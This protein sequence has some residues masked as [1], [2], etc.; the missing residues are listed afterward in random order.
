M[1]YLGTAGWALSQP[2]AE[3]FPREGSQLQR[4][5][6]GLNA[7]E[8]N[9]SFY[10]PHRPAT[11]ARWAEAV[12]PDFRFCVKLPKAITHERRLVAC[13]AALDAFLD[14]CGELGQRLGCLLVQLPPSLV[15]DPAL[16]EAFLRALR[17][18]HEG[19][20]VIEPRHPSWQQAQPLLD[21][22]RI[23][24]AAVDPSRF[25][26]DDQPSGW[27]GLVYWRLHGTP[28]MYYS[29]YPAPWLDAFTRRL[30]DSAASG[31]PVWC[32]FDNTAAG[33]ALGNALSLRARVQAQADQTFA[34]PRPLL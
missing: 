9:S 8:I 1:I 17:A 7:V 2:H 20:L 4:Y 33:A 18:R 6:S 5:A 34:P 11:Y 22:L 32:I 28:R 27:A 29:D 3:H 13:E 16:V 23:A 14:G 15:F 19:G 31:V 24:R 26:G 10:R 12:P 21:D 30:L 25:T